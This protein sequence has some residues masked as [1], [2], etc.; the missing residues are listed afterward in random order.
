MADKRIPERSDIDPKDKW[1]IED[2]FP[3]DKA[4]EE[5][6]LKAGEYPEA[7]SGFEGRLR[8][9]GKALLD[10]FKLDDEITYKL[11]DLIHYSSRKSDEDTRI[12][13]YSGYALA[14]GC[15]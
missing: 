9:S 10:Y 14:K 7:I 11:T 12:S 8:E 15:E 3:D 4:F 6:L 5:A 13:L 2:I 1:K